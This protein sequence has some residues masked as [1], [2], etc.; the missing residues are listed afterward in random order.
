MSKR[1]TTKDLIESLRTLSGALDSEGES[2]SAKKV[3]DVERFAKGSSSEFFG[4]ARLALIDFVDE[5][6]TR[7]SDPVRATV[8]DLIAK[9]SEEFRVVNGG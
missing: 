9:I 8:I 1:F 7:L 2:K 3:K 6:S 4:E 5:P